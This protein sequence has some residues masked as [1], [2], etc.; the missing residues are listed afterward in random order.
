MD[1]M[2]D[3]NYNLN[4]LFIDNF[5]T[6]QVTNMA[7]MFNQCYNLTSL[8]LK[9]FNTSR[10]WSMNFMF[11]RCYK[12]KE[13]NLVS[14]N[15][16]KCNNF[17]DMFGELNETKIYVENRADCSNLISEIPEELINFVN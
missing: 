12:L 1:F 14:F 5:D 8:D 2:F 11:N 4:K 10:V 16:E 13:L 9:N 6:S 7:G 17:L 3:S 15:T